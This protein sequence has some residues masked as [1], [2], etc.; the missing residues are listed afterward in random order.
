MESNG[1]KIRSNRFF[2]TFKRMK[3][4]KGLILWGILLLTALAIRFYSTSPLRVENGYSGRFY[5]QVSLF[6][7]SLFGWIPFSIGDVIYGLFFGWVMWRL[8]K[9]V[10]LIWLR[11]ATRRG[12]M[13]SLL[14]SIG[15]LLIIYVIFN[16]FWGI[17]YNRKGIAH[18]LDLKLEKYSP[19]DL[20]TINQ[21]LVE[22]VN[23]AKQN[24]LNNPDTIRN[25]RQLFIRVQ[26]AYERA[27]D[28]YPFLKY[29]NSSIKSSLW[30]WLGNYLGFTGYYKPFY[31]VAPGK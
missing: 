25:A 22:K 10:K 19:G 3:N 12:T 21:L 29:R 6:L 4:K 30:G 24:L 18:Q 26:K 16:L 20:K 7:R 17:N 11:Q 14:K 23:S 9:G 28:L 13:R 15:L 2:A 8:G 5:Q 31:M 1:P 27:D